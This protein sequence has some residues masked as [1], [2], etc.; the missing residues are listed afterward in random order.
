MAGLAPRIEWRLLSSR[1]MCKKAMSKMATRQEREAFVDA[2][3]GRH[4]PGVGLDQ[5]LP[6]ASSSEA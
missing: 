1:L 4:R 5:Q 2:C 6:V 3:V